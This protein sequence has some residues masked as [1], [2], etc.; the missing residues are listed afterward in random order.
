MGLQLAK[1][2]ISQGGFDQ[3]V[4]RFYI[5]WSLKGKITF[6]RVP[7]NKTMFTVSPA[8]SPPT[9]FSPITGYLTKHRHRMNDAQCA[10][11]QRVNT[12]YFRTTQGIV[13]GS[14]HF[15]YPS[16]N[17]QPCSKPPMNWQSTSRIAF[18]EDS[19]SPRTKKLNSFSFNFFWLLKKH[20]TYLSKCFKINIRCVIN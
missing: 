8:W 12:S 11:F 2:R 10:R 4:P 18:T 1:L 7:F 19:V 6:Q 20:S 16:T 5:W 3:R 15:W 17:W 14:I 9:A 13:I